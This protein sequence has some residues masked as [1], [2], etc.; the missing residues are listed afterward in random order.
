MRPASPANSFEYKWLRIILRCVAVGLGIAQTWATRT[1]MGSDGIQYLD[2][3]DAYIR[4]DW[5]MALNPIWSPLY[6]WLLA[7]P[8]KILKPSAY[9]EFPVVHLVNLFIYLGTLA[10]FDF[11]LRAMVNT[12]LKTDASGE[13]GFAGLPPWAWYA[14]G[15]TLFLWVVFGLMY[16]ETVTPDLCLAAFVCLAA[17]LVVRIRWGCPGWPHCILLGAV[18]GLGYLTKAIFF[19][20]SFIFLGGVLFSADDWRKAAP[21]VL[22][23]T[24]LFLAISAPLIVA[25][26]IS[27]GHLTY[28]EVGKY[29][30]VNDVDRPGAYWRRDSALIHPVNR[31][32]ESPVIAEFQRPDKSTF[33]LWYNP[34][35]FMEGYRPHFEWRGQVKAL[36]AS[37]FAYYGFLLLKET[38]LVAGAIV[39]LCAG[40]GLGMTLRAFRRNLPLLVPALAGLGAYALLHF[41]GRLIGP[42]VLL[43]WV[44]ILASVTL[45]STPE[46]RK[47]TWG[48]VFAIVVTMGLPIL[49]SAFFDV[50]AARRNSPVDWEVA[51]ALHQKGVQAGDKVGMIRDETPSSPWFDYYWARLARIQIIAEIPPEEVDTFWAS[52]PAVQDGAIKAFSKAGAKAVITSD[53]PPAASASTWQKLGNTN[54]YAC[55][56]D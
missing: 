41:D 13:K 36:K 10:S 45:P 34:Y 56:P 33:A 43:L 5:H 26:S 39:L 55:L 22:A 14:T 52:S 35:Y 38:G 24:A 21:R 12:R 27:Q 25:L 46:S 47:W 48:A 31:I 19:P 49:I 50:A 20:L 6:S 40:P 16:L 8:L 15:Y 54:F 9:W 42:F 23:A 37:A 2:M 18:L 11:L 17:G 32:Y 7:V 53:P 51:Q 30:Y 4:G 28:G 29:N 3:G 44:G 1:S